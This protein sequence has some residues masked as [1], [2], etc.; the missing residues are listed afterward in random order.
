M[1]VEEQD[2]FRELLSGEDFGAL[3]HIH[4]VV[5][6]G[7]SQR[8]TC[9]CH[10]AC[11][12]M[13]RHAEIEDAEID[14][15]RTVHL[16]QQLS[17]GPSSRPTARSSFLAAKGTPDILCAVIKTYASR[18]MWNHGEL[19]ESAWS[20]RFCCSRR[21]HQHVRVPSSRHHIGP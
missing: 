21:A 19:W 5:V 2:C 4:G 14:D 15:R 7:Y 10:E 9:Q 20:E 12:W 16:R 8:R 13:Q 1:A 6:I 11:L 3:S 18:L 17:H